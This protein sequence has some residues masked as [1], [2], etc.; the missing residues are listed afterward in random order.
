MGGQ[1]FADWTKALPA[2]MAATQ[3]V[4][5]FAPG[6]EVRQADFYRLDFTVGAN[7][8]LNGPAAGVTAARP[9]TGTTVCGVQFL[10]P[11][12]QGAKYGPIAEAVVGSFGPAKP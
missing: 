4:R 2:A 12:G 9:A 7:P 6:Q 5:D 10:Y 3:G 11:Q 8:Y 1:S